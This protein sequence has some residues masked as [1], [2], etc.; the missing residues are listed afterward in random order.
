[1]GVAA[2]LALLLPMEAGVPIPIPADLLMLFVGQ[3]A[4]A[5]EIPLWA[6]V[7][8]LEAVTLAGTAG[9]FLLV[10]GPAGSVLRRFGRRFGLTPER[11]ARA[12]D[13]LRRRGRNALIVGR[14]TP[15]LRTLTVATAAASGLSAGRALPPLLAGSTIFIQGHLVLGFLLGPLAE[16]ALNRARGP[17]LIA[18]V[19]LAAMGVLVWIAWRGRRGAAQRWTEASCPACLAVAALTGGREEAVAS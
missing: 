19:V 5:G 10:R 17:F 3:R 1:V 11:I 16:E 14:T 2:A 15:G 13:L 7:L 12:E 9:L 18:L 8:A 4:G 6:A